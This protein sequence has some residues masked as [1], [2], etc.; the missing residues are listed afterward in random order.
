MKLAVLLFSGVMCAGAGTI[1]DGAWGVYFGKEPAVPYRLHTYAFP[2]DTEGP[3]M[4][5]AKPQQPAELGMVGA[6]G[7]AASASWVPLSYTCA[8]GTGVSPVTCTWSTAV[9]AGASV[10]CMAYNFTNAATFTMSDSHSNSYTSYGSVIHFTTGTSYQQLFYFS[11]LPT[12]ITTTTMTVATGTASFP[13]VTCQA[14]TGGPV[15]A[16]DGTSTGSSVSTSPVSLSPNITTSNNGDFIFCASVAAGSVTSMTTGTGY[17]A[18]SSGAA[19]ALN[20]Y[21]TQT[22]AG[23]LSPTPSVN[24]SPTSSG[25]ASLLCGAFTP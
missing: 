17:T 23:P 15:T 14:A 3:Q 24:F 12:S 4:F 13:S 25:D 7:P 16:T 9:P 6:G 10:F 11:H 20:I 21:A 2:A 5:L 8:H 22:L 1:P 19:N 18:G